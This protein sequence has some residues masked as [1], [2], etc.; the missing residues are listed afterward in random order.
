MNARQ[1]PPIFGSRTPCSVHSIYVLTLQQLPAQQILN[2]HAATTSPRP[3]P[4]IR[5]VQ[6]HQSFCEVRENCAAPCAEPG[7]GSG[8]VL[9]GPLWK[10][11][12]NIAAEGVCEACALKAGEAVKDGDATDARE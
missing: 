4:T 3:A 11:L 2:T 9:G 10:G 7:A 5:R 12:L 8:P 6:H 1:S